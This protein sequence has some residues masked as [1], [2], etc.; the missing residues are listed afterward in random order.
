MSPCPQ[1]FNFCIHPFKIFND[2][3]SF[4]VLF[5]VPDNPFSFEMFRH[6]NNMNNILRIKVQIQFWP[7]LRDILC[8]ITR[9]I[10]ENFQ[11]FAHSFLTKQILKNM[12]R[13]S[14][15]IILIHKTKDNANYFIII[16]VLQIISV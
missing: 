13:T 7:N 8:D 16:I 3:I 12:E 6:L 2:Y 5:P 15:E 9:N 10:Y 1:H 11:S 14:L 4:W